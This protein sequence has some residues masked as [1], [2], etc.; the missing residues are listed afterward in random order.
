MKDKILTAVIPTHGAPFMKVLPNTLEAFQE[1]VGGYIEVVPLGTSALM[2]LNEEGKLLG[3]DYNCDYFGD[4]LCGNIVIV[5]EGGEDFADCPQIFL[6]ML[7]IINVGWSYLKLN[8]IE[9][10]EPFRSSSVTLAL[11]SM[12]NTRGE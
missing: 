1:E 10:V 5:G 12:R 6:D 11:E 2:V 8:G 7:N 3:L 9:F 4:E